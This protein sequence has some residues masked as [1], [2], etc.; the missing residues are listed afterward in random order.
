MVKVFAFDLDGTLTQHKTSWK[1]LNASATK[2]S[3]D[4]TGIKAIFLFSPHS[5]LLLFVGN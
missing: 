2:Q 3:L 4:T 1:K 5:R